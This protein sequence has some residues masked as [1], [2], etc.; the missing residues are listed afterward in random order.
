MALKSKIIMPLSTQDKLDLARAIVILRMESREWLDK[1]ELNRD[2]LR[3]HDK[4]ASFAA[5]ERYSEL[6]KIARELEV[7]ATGG[8]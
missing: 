3:R 8:L 7:I 6:E 1:S 2:S 5:Y 4:D